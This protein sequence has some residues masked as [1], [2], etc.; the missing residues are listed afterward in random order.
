MTQGEER[1]NAQLPYGSLAMI[2]AEWP[3]VHGPESLSYEGGP[4]FCQRGVR[5][6]FFTFAAGFVILQM[7]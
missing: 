4:P 2:V 1:R 6:I 3:V 7:V 5:E